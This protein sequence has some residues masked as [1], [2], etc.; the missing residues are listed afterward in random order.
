[1]KN[2]D[3]KNPCNRYCRD[4][5]VPSYDHPDGAIDYAA[6]DAADAEDLAELN[7]RSSADIIAAALSQIEAPCKECKG[8]KLMSYHVIKLIRQPWYKRLIGIRAPIR[9]D[10]DEVGVP[11]KRCKGSGKEVPELSPVAGV[12]AGA[13]P[14]D[15]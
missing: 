9:Q 15:T 8:A 2:D 3:L 11:C 14:A 5:C 13:H 7:G 1:M 6:K 12:D 10:R 4:D